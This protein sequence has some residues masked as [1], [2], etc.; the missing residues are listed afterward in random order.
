MS[1]TLTGLEGLPE[2]RVGD[3]IA[4]HILAAVELQD[5]DILVVTSKIIS[6]AEGRF[7]DVADR[8][9]AIS[10]ETVRVVAQ[11][12]KTRIVESRLG[13]VAAAAGLD[14]SNVPAG[15]ALLLP[16]DPD[17]S[18]RELC[19]ELRERTGLHIGVLVSDTVGRPWRLG[20]TDIAIG[21]AGVQLF[22]QPTADADGR[23]LKVTLPCIADEICG[24]AELVKP[25]AGNIPIALVR[26]LGDVVGDLD[27][28]G[29]RSIIRAPED[30]L[31]PTGVFE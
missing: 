21:A 3:R 5:G 22:D 19:R 16:E 8:E 26:G 13:I 10:R 15:T 30:D 17:A 18:A 29:A 28:P 31:F 2:I 14:E 1:I 7:I 23:P 20:Q 25:K 9:E 27:L 12:G 6:K 11:R 24:A 4:D